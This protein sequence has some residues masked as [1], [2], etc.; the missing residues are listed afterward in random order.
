MVDAGPN[1]LHHALFRNY[2]VCC[3]GDFQYERVLPKFLHSDRHA[4]HTHSKASE[5]FHVWV[6]GVDGHSD[7]HV[8]LI[9]IKA[10]CC[11]GS[12]TS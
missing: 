7:F 11:E 2:L 12:E 3:I 9:N 1:P 8:L 4:L 10:H 5:K 6:D